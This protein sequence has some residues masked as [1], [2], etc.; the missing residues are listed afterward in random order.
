MEIIIEC[1]DD[2]R[3]GKNVYGEPILELIRCKDCKYFKT[4]GGNMGTCDKVL[5]GKFTWI[6]WYCAD[7]E[8]IEE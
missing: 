6:N 2:C 7:G 8:R 4:I 3:G 1:S 5:S